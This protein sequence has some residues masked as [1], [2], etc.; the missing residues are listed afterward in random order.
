LLGLI[1]LILAAFLLLKVKNEVAGIL[2]MVAGLACTVLPL[3]V[4]M[5]MM[6]VV[7]RG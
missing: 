6:A 4:L 7:T 3:A 1:L 2:V 5:F